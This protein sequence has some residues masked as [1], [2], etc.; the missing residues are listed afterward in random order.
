MV[1]RHLFADKNDYELFYQFV[2]SIMKVEDVKVV[3]HKDYDKKIARSPMS[4]DMFSEM[5]DVM[6]RI[7]RKK[8]E[9][10]ISA[11]QNGNT[12]C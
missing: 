2:E 11:K 7:T 10:Y 6:V 12:A 5:Y 4:E 3:S 8:Y 1:K 9:D